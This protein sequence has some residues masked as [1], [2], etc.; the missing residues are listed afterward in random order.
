MLIYNKHKLLKCHCDEILDI[1]FFLHFVHNRSFL[2]ILSNFNLLRTLELAVF[3]PLFPKFTA[4]I[5][6][7]VSSLG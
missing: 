2:D 3:W 5:N 6:F 7:L 1:H 4:V